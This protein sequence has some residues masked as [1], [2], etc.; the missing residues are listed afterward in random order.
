MAGC[1]RRISPTYIYGSIAHVWIWYLADL[2]SRFAPI[3]PQIKW[4]SHQWSNVP[5][6]EYHITDPSPKS[7]LYGETSKLFFKPLRKEWSETLQWHHNGHDSVSNHQPHDCLLNRLFRRRSKKTS[8]LLVTGLC[9]GNSPGTGEF[10]AQMA[11]NEENVS[12]WWRHHEK[13]RNMMIF[14]Y[15]WRMLRGTYESPVD[16]LHNGPLM[17]Y[18]DISFLSVW[19]SCWINSQVVSDIRHQDAYVYH[20]NGDGKHTMAADMSVTDPNPGWFLTFSGLHISWIGHDLV[21]NL[22]I[23]GAPPKF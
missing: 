19:T 20:N 18:I 13:D 22:I 11:S 3:S 14:P 5:Q 2:T 12:I 7:N 16:S 17:Q 8:K 9:A 1:K 15:Y 6:W 10:P 21:Q 23:F 4:K